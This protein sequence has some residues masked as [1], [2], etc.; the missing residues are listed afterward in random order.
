MKITKSYIKKLIKEE[1]SN[2]LNE[3]DLTPE[4]VQRRMKNIQDFSMML[5]NFVKKKAP[6]LEFQY[7]GLD[8][9]KSP[10][11][12]FYASMKDK[13]SY[14][15]N[16]LEYQY[17]NVLIP[18]LEEVKTY[19]ESITDSMYKSDAERLMFIVNKFLALKD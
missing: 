12:G 2:V 13:D 19:L 6:P 15:Y 5:K 8:L 11:Y 17:Q 16:R 1:L 14:N 10:A 9:E 3:R 7:N 4:E 18:A